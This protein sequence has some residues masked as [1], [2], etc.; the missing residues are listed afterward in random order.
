MDIILEVYC[1]ATIAQ[2]GCYTPLKERT[3]GYRLAIYLKVGQPCILPSLICGLEERDLI[4]STKSTQYQLIESSLLKMLYLNLKLI[5][6]V[7]ANQSTFQYE[8]QQIQSE[9]S[10]FAL[11]KVIRKI[12]NT[13][14]FSAKEFLNLF[15][16]DRFDIPFVQFIGVIKN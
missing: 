7:E 13:C 14:Q 8:G 3:Q 2:L 6:N 4:N 15:V 5:K 9:D 12:Y 16:G 11:P 1:S 10:K